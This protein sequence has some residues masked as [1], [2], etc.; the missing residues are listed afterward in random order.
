LK[1]ENVELRQREFSNKD[2][3]EELKNNLTESTLNH[4]KG[5]REKKELKRK[6]KLVSFNIEE[7]LFI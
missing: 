7:H 6:L 5:K 2:K 1:I 4:E 3:V